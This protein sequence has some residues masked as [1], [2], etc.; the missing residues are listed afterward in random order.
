MTDGDGGYEADATPTLAGT[1]LQTHHLQKVPD[2]HQEPRPTN[3]SQKFDHVN[4]HRLMQHDADIQVCNHML[5]RA[6]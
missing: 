3:A 1:H 4:P 6:C 5:L 2:P